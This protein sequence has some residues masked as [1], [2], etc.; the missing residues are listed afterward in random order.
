MINDENIYIKAPGIPLFHDFVRNLNSVNLIGEIELGYC[1]LPN[2]YIAI[3]GTNGKTTTTQ[4]AEFLLRQIGER[5]FVG[6]NIGQPLCDIIWNDN[7]DEFGC[8]LLELSSFQLETL[9]NFKADYAGLTNFSF[10]HGEHHPDEN[11]YWQAKK[12]IFAGCKSGY[13]FHHVDLASVQNLKDDDVDKFKSSFDN[14]SFNFKGEFNWNNLLLAN[15]LVV[16]YMNESSSLDEL[17]LSQ[18]N[19]K[20]LAEFRLDHYR[21][22]FEKKIK[23]I[24]F[25]NDSKS[26]NFSSTISALKSFSEPVVLIIGGKR[27]GKGD[28]IAPHIVEMKPFVKE[29]IFIG[30]SGEDMYS[31]TNL[32]KYFFS[33]GGTE[34]Y[35]KAIIETNQEV[36]VLFSPA[37]PSFDQFKDY[38]HRGEEFSNLITK[39]SKTT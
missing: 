14:K 10:H 5:V 25:Y 18:A 12:R 35:L 3:T 21:L 1:F 13:S 23:S 27:R 37:F 22:Q 28:S 32:G 11:D 29:F 2:T 24:N 17:K 8:I 36:T 30:E 26:T 16:D 38:K 7:N 34:S 9:K 6:G 20:L 15:R 39:L 4:M 33:L 31:E 19:Q